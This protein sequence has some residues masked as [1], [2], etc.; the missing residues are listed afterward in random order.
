[1]VKIKYVV[2]IFL[3]FVSMFYVSS[4]VEA[5]SFSKIP[6]ELGLL[7]NTGVSLPS[8]AA[9]KDNFT[10]DKRSGGLFYEFKMQF[11][12]AAWVFGQFLKGNTEVIGDFLTL[13]FSFAGVLLIIKAFQKWGGDN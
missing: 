11:K 7:K 10:R 3:L 8:C 13:I 1:M 4:F 9:K 6:T 5:F 12:R 2:C